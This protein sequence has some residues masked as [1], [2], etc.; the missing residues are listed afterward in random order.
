MNN[1]NRRQV[2]KLTASAGAAALAAAA[3][4]AADPPITKAERDDPQP[5]NQPKAGAAFGKTPKGNKEPGVESTAT[6]E[7]CGPRELFAVVDWDG[8]LKRGMHVV[9]ARRLELG[10]Y[11]VVFN[12]DV[13][14]GVYLVTPGGHG[15]VGIP[16]PAVVSAIGRATDPRGV[17]VYICDLQGDPLAC[18][19]HLLVVCPEGFA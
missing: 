12:R 1:M 4:R 3:S 6:A 10:V 15:Y 11:E 17:L 7:H 19:F 2:M 8:K 18:A 14:R 5:V 13:R 9:S 16:L